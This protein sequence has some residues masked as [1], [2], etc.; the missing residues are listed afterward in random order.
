M[1]RYLRLASFLATRGIRPPLTGAAEVFLRSWTNQ[2]MDDGTYSPKHYEREDNSLTQLFADVLP[3][4]RPDDAILDVGCNCGR[5]LNYLRSRGFTNLH[6]IEIG[7]AAVDRMG[8]IFPETRALA[9]VEVGSAPEVL[10]HHPDRQYALVFC[11]SVLVNIP[12][13]FNS[14][15]ADMARVSSRYV[16]LIENEASWTSFPRDFQRMFEAEGFR[17]VAYKFLVESVGGM[18]LPLDWRHETQLSNNVL[19]VFVRN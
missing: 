9:K 7:Q 11:H 10:R 18:E 12:S 8:E 15:V 6:G 16:V 3:R 2:S 5:A 1:V 4:L 13:S 14:V 17:Q 19:R